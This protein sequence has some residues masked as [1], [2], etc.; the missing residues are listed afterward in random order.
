L[1]LGKFF[2]N[3]RTVT[4]VMLDFSVVCLEIFGGIF[5]GKLDVG[6]SIEEAEDFD[7]EQEAEIPSDTKAS[8]GNKDMR[9][10]LEDLLDETRLSKQLREYDF[11]DF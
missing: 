10:R 11:R 9:R 4:F 7:S 6:S 1:T 8:T 3:F 5:M 2:A